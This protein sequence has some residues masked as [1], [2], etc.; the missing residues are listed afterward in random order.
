MYHSIVVGTDG[1][2]T[3]NLALQ[4]AC[5]LAR[6]CGATLHVVHAYQQLSPTQMAGASVAAGPSIDVQEINNGIAS[7]AEDLLSTA[8]GDI[9]LSGIDVQRHT[10]PG[11]P[12]EALLAA[13]KEF[14]AD[15]IVVGNRGMSGVR[16]F[17]LGSVPNKVSHHCPCSLL[18][19]DTTSGG[20]SSSTHQARAPGEDS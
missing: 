9:D 6:L 19:I 4:R 14:D 11:D 12:A 8:T 5:D 17:V 18:I 3:A 13:A 16:R 2:A 20:S 1:S 15:L 10:R 7:A